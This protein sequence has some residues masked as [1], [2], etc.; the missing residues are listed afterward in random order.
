MPLSCSSSKKFSQHIQD[1]RSNLITWYQKRQRLRGQVCVCR[2]FVKLFRSP[3]R[4]ETF[5][6]WHFIAWQRVRGF[7]L[8]KSRKTCSQACR[9]EM[10]SII[11]SRIPHLMDHGGKPLS[12]QRGTDTSSLFIMLR[13]I[14]HLI[15]SLFSL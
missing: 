13:S 15:S 11:I 6:T 1:M 2:R 5:T 3:G 14:S 12:V 8:A 4:D 7:R 9:G 10:I